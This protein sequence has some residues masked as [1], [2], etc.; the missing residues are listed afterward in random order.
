MVTWRERAPLPAPRAGY[1]AGVWESKLVIGG[2]T[3]WEGD[4]K[5]WTD[6]TDLFDPATNVWLPGPPLPV[7][8][9]DC[10]CAT[11]GGR[12]YTLGGVVAEAVSKDVVTFDGRTW[13][14]AGELPVALMYSAAAVAGDAVYLL[15]GLTK[16]GELTSATTGLYQWRPGGKWKPLSPFPGTPRVGAAVTAV[17]DRLYVFGGIHMAE[18]TREMH[19]LGDAWSYDTMRDQWTPGASLPVLRRAWGAVAVNDGALILGG[20]TD[21]FSREVFHFSPQTN[22]VTP[23]ADLPHALADAKYFRIGQCVYTTGG[24][25]GIKI[26]GAW[27]LE[28]TWS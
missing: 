12:I 20:Y 19:N 7:P 2:G 27:T 25:S 16:F 6:R 17:G 5:I 1:A 8:R 24:E 28:G 11:V 13:K 9:S 22:P 15:G 23:M 4:R 14:A 26:R 10:A 18:S 21:T 3:R